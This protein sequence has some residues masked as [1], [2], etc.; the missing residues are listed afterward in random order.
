[1]SE[2]TKEM[3]GNFLQS[4]GWLMIMVL[5]LSYTGWYYVLNAL[6]EYKKEEVFTL[7]TESYGVKNEAI[8]SNLQND[9]K[10]HG[11]LKIEH[12]DF[13]PNR[14]NIGDL[15]TRFGADSDVLILKEKD[16]V[17]MEDVIGEVFYTTSEVLSY[18]PN[19]SQYEFYTDSEI[20]CGLKVYDS[21]N[22]N[23]NQNLKFDQFLNFENAETPESFYLLINRGSIHFEAIADV[24][25]DIMNKIFEEI[26][27]G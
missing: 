27:H 4:R 13:S 3:I 8:I 25:V 14:S 9:F 12:Y 11:I 24:G 20:S 16:L 21:E 15:Y 7:F 10:E 26:K 1:M 5:L 19:W 2:K 23:Y 22:K 17:D 6:N 18:F